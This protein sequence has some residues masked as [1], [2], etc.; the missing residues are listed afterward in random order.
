MT[1]KAERMASLVYELILHC[2][3]TVLLSPLTD[4]LLCA[5]RFKLNKQYPLY[6]LTMTSA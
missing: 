2:S 4:V 1:K 5:T 6:I 3:A